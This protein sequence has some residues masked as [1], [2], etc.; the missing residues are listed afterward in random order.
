MSFRSLLTVRE[1]VTDREARAQ[2]V[3]TEP[4]VYHGN[5]D[6][7]EIPS[8]FKTDFA[9]VPRAFWS[10]LPP[11]GR[12]KKAAVV[13]DWLYAGHGVASRR[14]AD[15]IFIRMMREL[16]VSLWRRWTMWAAVRLF[17]WAAWTKR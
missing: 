16:G 15:A 2:W 9:S 3:L 14:E 6:Q 5:F 17:G 4:L 12:Y 8:G 11:W 10:L 13:H 1:V 7:W